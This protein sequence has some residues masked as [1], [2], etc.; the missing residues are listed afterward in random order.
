[1]HWASLLSP[2]DPNSPQCLV[3]AATRT[4]QAP[5]PGAGPGCCVQAGSQQ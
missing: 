1:M 4:G 5:L 3:P 2:E